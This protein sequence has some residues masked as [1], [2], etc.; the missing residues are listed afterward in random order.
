[1]SAGALSLGAC[2]TTDQVARDQAAA[3]M[4][5]A[6]RAE[7]TANAAQSTA[8]ATAEKVERMF[9]RGLRK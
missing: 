2:S 6:Q 1:M 3:A 5:T 9:Q 4:A 8:N 7:A